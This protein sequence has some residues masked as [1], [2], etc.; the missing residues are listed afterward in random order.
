MSLDCTRTE[1]VDGV[2]DPIRSVV[3][4][5]SLQGQQIMET[6]TYIFVYTDQEPQYFPILSAKFRSLPQLCVWA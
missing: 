5:Q 3:S 4:R 2:K 1:Y 6:V